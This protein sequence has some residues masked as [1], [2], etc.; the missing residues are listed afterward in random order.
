[1]IFEPE[2]EKVTGGWRNLRN[3]EFHSGHIGIFCLR[4]PL[5][6]P[7]KDIPF[8]SAKHLCSNFG[9]MRVGYFSGLFS[10]KQDK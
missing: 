6:L 4:T 2:R 5:E 10:K 9:K 3:A 8:P 1:V 7:E